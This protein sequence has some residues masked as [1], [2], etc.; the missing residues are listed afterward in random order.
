MDFFQTAKIIL[1]KVMIKTNYK[2][3]FDI[4]NQPQSL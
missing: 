3:K 2:Q 1:T 4:V